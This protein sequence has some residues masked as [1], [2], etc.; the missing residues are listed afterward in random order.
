MTQG[1]QRCCRP[2]TTRSAMRSPMCCSTRVR[3]IWP[4]FLIS[5]LTLFLRLG[6]TPRWMALL[7][8][9]LAR[10]LLIVI[11]HVRWISLVFPLSVLLVSFH[12]LVENMRGAPGALSQN[13]SCECQ[14]TFLAPFRVLL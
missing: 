5:S 12:I 13:A 2:A 8:S 10:A 3:C 14:Y 4:L 6:V 1:R 7:G 11:S 9:A